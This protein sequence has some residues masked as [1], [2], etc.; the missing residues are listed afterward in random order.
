[1]K[2]EASET[3]LLL[4]KDLEAQLVPFEMDGGDS[5]DPTGAD[6]GKSPGKSQGDITKL[7]DTESRYVS[8]VKLSI[9][10]RFA[11]WISFRVYDMDRDMLVDPD[12]ADS[13]SNE[14]PTIADG[15]SAGSD[16]SKGLSTM[17][18]PDPADPSSSKKEPTPEDGKPLASFSPSKEQMTTPADCDA[19]NSNS[20]KEPTTSRS[21][22][23]DADPDPGANVYVL[24]CFI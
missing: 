20:S 7:D 13:S 12:P 8:H 5:G 6:Q 2:E 19:A 23:S 24:H 21:T 18:D 3:E 22:T 9:S 1:V 4:S 10:I 16:S 14:Q 11:H 15:K 17:A